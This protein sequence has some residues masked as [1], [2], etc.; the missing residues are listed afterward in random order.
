V[1]SERLQLRKSFDAFLKW[2]K[3]TTPKGVQGIMKTQEFMKSKKSKKP[4]GKPDPRQTDFDER[5]VDKQ[6]L[7]KS[8]VEKEKIIKEN[9]P[10][11]K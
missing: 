4:K 2:L 5:K 1:L 3:V 11:R 8:I 10:I 9:K 7:E 6:K